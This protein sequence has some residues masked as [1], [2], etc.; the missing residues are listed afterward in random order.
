MGET[1]T[2][3]TVVVGGGKYDRHI[4]DF[5]EKFHIKALIKIHIPLL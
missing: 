1:Y 4:H 3:Q 2:T 5:I